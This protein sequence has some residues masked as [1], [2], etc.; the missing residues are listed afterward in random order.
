MRIAIHFAII[1]AA[2]LLAWLGIYWS[3]QGF[4]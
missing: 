3:L 4:L 2:G 1:S